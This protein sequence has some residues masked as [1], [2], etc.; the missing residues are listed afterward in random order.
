[1][2]VTQPAWASAHAPGP[3]AKEKAFERSLTYHAGVLTVRDARIAL[4]RGFRYIGPR[5]AQRTLT[6]YGNPRH[7]EVLA[8]ILPPHANALN[9]IYFIVVTYE[10]DG[11]VSDKDAAKIDFDAMLRSMQHAEKADNTTRVKNGYEP[12]QT[13]GWAERPHYDTTTHK[14]YWASDLLFGTHRVGT[15]NYEVRT[16]GREGMLALNAVATMPDIA[17]VRSGMQTVL[18]SSQF[19]PGRRYQDFHKGDRVSKLTVAAVVAGGAFTLAKTG[20]LAVLLAKLKFIA[21]GIAALV[22]G[23][24]KRL[25]RRSRADSVGG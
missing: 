5:D 8:M 15:V 22:G 16:L 3:T 13:V 20:L 4:P 21:L 14:L 11:H 9:N 1:M 23:L 10:N 6:L 7:P 2:L 17:T 24:R 12:I 18:A 19:V 25:F